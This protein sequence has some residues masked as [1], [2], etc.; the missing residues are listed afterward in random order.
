MI[1]VMSERR[2][3]RHR[4]PAVLIV[5]DDGLVAD[6]TA[7]AIEALGYRAIRARDGLQALEALKQEKPAMLLVDMSLP[8]MSGSEFLRFVRNNPIWSGIPRVIMTGT[9]D[10]MIGIREDAPVFYKPLDMGSLAA[11]VQRYCD[12][13]RPQLSAFEP[14]G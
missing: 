2:R 7:D 10:P 6:A 5:E 13:A 14:R 3:T 9:N 8:G 11:A 12:R 1:G 4:P